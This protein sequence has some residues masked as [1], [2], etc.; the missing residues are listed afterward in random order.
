[1][2]ESGA[3]PLSRC[4]ISPRKRGEKIGLLRGIARLRGEKFLLR[5]IA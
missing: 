1:M 3:P 2:V 5:G 4:D